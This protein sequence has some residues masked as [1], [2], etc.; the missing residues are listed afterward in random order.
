MTSPSLP[1]ESDMTTVEVFD[2][3]TCCDSGVCGADVDQELVTFAAEVNWA[4]GRGA[5]VRRYNLAR[6]PLAFAGHPVVAE[7]LGRSG[8]SSLPLVL[9]DGEAR[10]SGRYPTRG[11]LGGWLGLGSV[12]VLELLPSEC[13]GDGCTC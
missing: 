5:T 12:P 4:R 10:L 1:K 11:E 6:Q 2:P 7:L 3:A 13:C 9:V 8:P